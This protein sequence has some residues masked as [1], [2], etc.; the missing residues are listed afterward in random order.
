MFKA[1]NNDTRVT[2]VNSSGLPQHLLKC[3]ELRNRFLFLVGI[4][5]LQFGLIQCY[6]INSRNIPKTYSIGYSRPLAP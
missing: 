6:K 3:I 4:C 2:L 5:I 1:N